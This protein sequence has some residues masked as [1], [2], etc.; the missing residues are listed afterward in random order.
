ML[1]MIYVVKVKGEKFTLT[2][3]SPDP[4][5]VLGKNLGDYN[6]F[7]EA[8]KVIGKERHKK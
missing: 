6:S 7:E 1:E 4:A 5:S 8:C 2:K 3:K